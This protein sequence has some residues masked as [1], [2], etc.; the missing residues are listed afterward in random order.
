MLRVLFS[1]LLG[2]IRRRQ[3]DQEFD[4]EVNAHMEMLT[5]RFVGQGM[6]PEK[7]TSPRGGSLED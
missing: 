6:S 5:E 4:D 1:R 7:L 2:M 3:M